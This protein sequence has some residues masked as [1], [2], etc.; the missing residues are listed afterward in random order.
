MTKALPP[1]N[2]ET[3]KKLIMSSGQSVKLQTF[4]TASAASPSL[5]PK[6]SD[7][8][9]AAGVGLVGKL[10]DVARFELNLCVPLSL[11]HAKYPRPSLQFGIGTEFL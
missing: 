7:F 1:A 2:H 8:Q 11:G 3:V 4:L 5:Q 9:A 6:L 10:L